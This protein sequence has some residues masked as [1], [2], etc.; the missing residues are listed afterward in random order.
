[1][2][3]S[4]FR[5]ALVAVTAGLALYG[6]AA[7][8]GTAGGGGPV[9]SALLEELLKA[10]LLLGFGWAGRRMG[11]ED[12][13]RRLARC[14]ALGLARGLSLGLVAVTV[15]AGAENLAYLAAYREAGVLARLLWSLPV[16]LVA[17]L[18]EALGVLCLFRGR[19]AGSAFGC[20]LVAL[21]MGWHAAANLLAAHRLAFPAFAG[22]VAVANL[23][24]L[25]LLLQYLRHAYLGGFLHGA[26]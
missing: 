2:R 23:L 11:G 22:G 10:A 20:G 17:A 14:R 5:E 26:D 3:N 19:L 15:F 6:A 21:A 25:I 7:G 4:T 13:P 1:M 18:L 24:F 16:H 8:L 9:F 12:N